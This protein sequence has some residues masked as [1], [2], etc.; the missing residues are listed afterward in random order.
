HVGRPGI[1]DGSPSP[2]PEF[3][4]R[5][6]SRRLWFVTTCLCL[7]WLLVVGA[8]SR[9]AEGDTPESAAQKVDHYGDPLPAGAIFRFG[10]Q[11]FRPPSG[12]GELALSPDERIIVSQGDELI[13]WDTTTGKELWRSDGTEGGFNGIGA[14]YGI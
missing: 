2:Q 14:S 3:S 1:L 9:G 8:A 11:R 10:T 13:A 4:M 7:A 6:I 12:V 5:R